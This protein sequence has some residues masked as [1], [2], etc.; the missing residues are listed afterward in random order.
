[1]ILLGRLE[2]RSSDKKTG[3]Y[4]VIAFIR[5]MPSHTKHIQAE[6]VVKKDPLPGICVSDS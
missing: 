3:K 5:H 6:A 4:V 2:N 1:V